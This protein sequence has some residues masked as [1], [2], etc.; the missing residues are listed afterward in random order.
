MRHVVPYNMQ[1][2]NYETLKIPV[3]GGNNLEVSITEEFKAKVRQ[4]M[5]LKENEDITDD[6]IVNFIYSSFK[7]AIDKESLSHG[8]E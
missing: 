8:K 2:K 3:R 4:A 6:Q 1:V 7:N 5:S